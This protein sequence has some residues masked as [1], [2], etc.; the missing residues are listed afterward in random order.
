MTEESTFP[1]LHIQTVDSISAIGR[2]DWD[3]FAGSENPMIRYDVLEALEASG[4]VS[5]DSGWQPCH[6]KFYRD[7]HWVGVAP[8]YIKS[9]SMGEYV[10]DWAWADA[11]QR[12]GQPYYPKLV[13]AVPFTPCQG[14]RLLI[15]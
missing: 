9:H 10:F 12:H 7:N 2:S 14:P 6:L 1:D 15:A 13:V 5:R 8:A 11:W 4:S 3:G